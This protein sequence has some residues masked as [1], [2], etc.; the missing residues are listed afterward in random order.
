MVQHS[1]R[2]SALSAKSLSEKLSDII[3]DHLKSGERFPTENQLI[4]D[5]GVSRTALREALSAFEAKGII[6]AQRGSGRSVRMPDLSASLVETWSFVLKA[7][8]N[9]MLD[10]LEIRCILELN[11]LSKA[12]E[13]CTVDQLAQMSRLVENMNQLTEDT[14]AFASIDCEFH[15]AMFLT[16]GNRLLEQLLSAFSDLFRLYHLDEGG[17]DYKQIAQQHQ[18]ILEAFAKQDLTSLTELMKEHFADLR[19]RIAV[20]HHWDRSKDQQ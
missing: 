4:H 6:T 1:A 9:L 16:I 2:Q 19:Y 5:L 7:D 3:A 17:Y 8:P 11:S 12:M 20:L 13:R 10:F 15:K 14:Q 18:D